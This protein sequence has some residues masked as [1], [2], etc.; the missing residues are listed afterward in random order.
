MLIA[1]DATADSDRVASRAAR[2]AQIYGSRVT[3]LHVLEHLPTDIPV[4]PVPPEGVDKI[5]WFRNHALNKLEAL[6]DR[7]G[8]SAAGITVAVTADSARKEIV[9]FAQ[10]QDVDLIIIGAHERH[11]IVFLHGATTDGVVHKAPCD[12]LL[13]HI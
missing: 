4:E 11:G 6:A 1:T 5:E 3:L 13:V 7:T 8:L 9:R 12:V 10:E 2:I